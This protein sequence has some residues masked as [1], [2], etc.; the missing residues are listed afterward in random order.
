MNDAMASLGSLKKLKIDHGNPIIS[1]WISTDGHYGFLEFRTAEEA[2]LGF[3]LQGMVLQGNE[4][5][6]GRPKQ[7]QDDQHGELTAAL[8]LDAFDPI[9]LATQGISNAENTFTVYNPTPILEIKNAVTFELANRFDTC[10]TVHYDM[11]Q[12]CGQYGKVD[13]IK[14]P[15]P[16]WLGAEGRKPIE[17]AKQ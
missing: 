14:I 15:R 11:L 7:Y 2:V 16:I 10:R 1:S 12:M 5:K 13:Q 4:L 8:G 9:L 6:I 17:E 3:N